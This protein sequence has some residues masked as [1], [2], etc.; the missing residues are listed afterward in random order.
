MGE[1]SG[2]ASVRSLV[3]LRWPTAGDS[4]EVDLGRR[5]RRAGG[6]PD[7]VRHDHRPQDGLFRRTPVGPPAHGRAAGDRRLPGRGHRR[8]AG[9]AVP[10]AGA[11]A[12]KQA[13]PGR[14][15]RRR[16]HPAAAAP[17]RDVAGGPLRAGGRPARPAPLAGAGAG[18]RRGRAAGRR[19]APAAG[20]T[21]RL[22]AG[23][24]PVACRR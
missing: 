2:Y 1:D 12:R 18:R 5:P 10:R 9:R 23:L 13:L 15:R 22:G 20:G 11:A 7:R 24:R 3:W 6:R 14:A 17:G 8:A 21:G 4:G 19:P 16:R